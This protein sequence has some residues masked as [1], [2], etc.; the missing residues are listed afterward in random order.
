MNPVIISDDSP[1]LIG[2]DITAF[3]P[4]DLFSIE[5]PGGGGGGGGGGTVTLQHPFQ[6]LDT[7]VAA[8]TARFVVRYGTVNDVVPTDVAVTLV[9]TDD[10]TNYVQVELTLDAAGAITATA[11]VVNT[12]QQTDGDY[13]AYILLGTIVVTG[14]TTEAVITAVN[15][16][17]THSLRFRTC[18]RVED[19]FDPGGYYFWGV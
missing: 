11:L 3:D 7:S 2:P 18:D 13:L 12:S 17:V 4:I 15:Q 16:A 19:P 6:L 9:P 14:S 5:S 10:A 1:E 8:G